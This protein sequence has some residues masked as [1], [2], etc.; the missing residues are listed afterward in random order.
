MT[1]MKHLLSIADLERTDLEDLLELS[2]SFREVTQR[3]IPKVPA[4]R[5]KVVVSRYI[6]AFSAMWLSSRMSPSTISRSSLESGS[7]ARSRPE[8]GNRDSKAERAR[9]SRLFTD[10]SLVSSIPAASAAR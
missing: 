9:R 6:A 7:G 5:G 4:L 2:E 3:D 10:A 1:S 8:A